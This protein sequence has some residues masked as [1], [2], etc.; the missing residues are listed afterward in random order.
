MQ[1]S[2]G[3][4]SN[5]TKV[6]DI[7]SAS[8][9]GDLQL[10]KK[11]MDELPELIYAQY[12]YTPPIHFAV[13]EGHIELVKYLLGNGAYAPSYKTYPFQDTLQIIA[14]DRGHDEI[15]SLLDEYTNSS[16][17]QYSGDN[18]AIDFQRTL[19]QQQFEDAVDKADI[20]KTAAF[21]KTDPGLALDQT[22]FWGEGI[23][24]MPAKEN[25]R[26][27]ISLLLSY[28][29]KVPLVLKWAQY[30]YFEHNEGAV[31]MM[32]N[33]MYPD[34]MSWHHVTILHDM[35]QKGNIAKAA[36]L[37]QYGTNINALEEEYQSTPLG[38]AVRWGN[39]EMVEY[40][41]QQG[42]NLHLSGAAWSTPLAWAI[43]KGHTHIEKILRSAGATG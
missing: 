26:E 27:L 31:F 18:G 16:K 32:E 28:G 38:L 33:G 24:T 1:L 34:T 43:K 10:V 4:V 39:T 6:W 8:Y 20:K 36:L 29:A 41:L 21:L 3:I 12:N 25:D 5:T 42:A 17:Q 22:Y 15:A 13:R 9:K 30:Y 14:V 23:L 7:L 19:L 40:L 37:L 2:N 35:A 11:M